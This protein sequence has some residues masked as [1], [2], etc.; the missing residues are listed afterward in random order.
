MSQRGA[1]AAKS[2]PATRRRGA[3]LERAIF[4]AV[5]EE[6]VGVGYAALTFEGVAARARTSRP[7]LYRRWSTRAELVMAA[8]AGTL[9]ASTD[10]PDFGNVRSDVLAVLR[11]ARDRFDQVGRDVILG[12]TA[13]TASGGELSALGQDVLFGAM[14]RAVM[15]PVLERATERGEIDPARLSPRVLAL[16]LDLVRHDL[17]T[18]GVVDDDTLIEIV[19]CVFLP[20]VVP[21]R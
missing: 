19:D 11:W 7:V 14:R 3:E 9:P 15:T 12:L 8:L 2:Q 13:E 21:Q 17:L 1:P 20:L 16:P 4:Q 10:V 18:F 6:L 5:T